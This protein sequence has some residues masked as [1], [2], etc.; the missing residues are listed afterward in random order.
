ML[1]LPRGVKRCE[2]VASS[3]FCDWPLIQ[4]WQRASSTAWFR[5]RDVG[6]ET[7]FLASVSVTPGEVALCVA[8]QAD[9]AVVEGTVRL[10]RE[11]IGGCFWVG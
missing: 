4:P 7:P 6:V 9:Q 10:G 5:V 8:S 3:I 11:F 2:Y 1:C